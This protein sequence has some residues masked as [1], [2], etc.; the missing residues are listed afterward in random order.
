MSK[1]IGTMKS[2][3]TWWKNSIRVIWI[4]RLSAAA[5]ERLLTTRVQL[6]IHHCHPR[7]RKMKT[8]CILGNLVQLVLRILTADLRRQI[9]QTSLSNWRLSPNQIQPLINLKTQE[10]SPMEELSVRY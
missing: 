10:C 3:Q 6:A 9:W 7:R 4:S 1:I 5:V 2:T 8:Y